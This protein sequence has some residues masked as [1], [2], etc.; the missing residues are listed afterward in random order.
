MVLGGWAV[1]AD[2]SPGAS[3]GTPPGLGMSQPRATREVRTLAV[4]LV[5]A[6]GLHRALAEA[7]Q[8]ERDLAK[9]IA[10]AERARDVTVR[11][12]GYVERAY[13]AI[14]AVD[15]KRKDEVVW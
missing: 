8:A 13:R 4:C 6:R 10:S 1:P 15:G 3:S 12:A 5:A 14:A 9:A 11:W 7:E 2:R